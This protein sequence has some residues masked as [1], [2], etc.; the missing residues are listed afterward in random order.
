MRTVVEFRLRGHSLGIH[1]PVLVDSDFRIKATHAV[2]AHLA[3]SQCAEAVGAGVQLA[4]G[5]NKSNAVAFPYFAVETKYSE[6]SV[7]AEQ[8]ISREYRLPRC[9]VVGQKCSNGP[10]PYFA[11]EPRAVKRVHHASRENQVER[12]L[13]VIRI[14]LE[15]G[16]L[17]RKE[18][19]KALVHRDLRIVRLNLA[20]IRIDGGIK[21]QAVFD[22]N[23]GVEAG[24]GL[25]VFPGKTF[26]RRIALV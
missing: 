12:S 8:W 3:F 21:H 25:H 5:V 16:P 22:D 26:L 19:L 20:K 2:V 11:C 7:V 23:L 4:V 14:F 6:I 24:F 1:L 17:L 10:R 13:E 9:T 15:E 18:H